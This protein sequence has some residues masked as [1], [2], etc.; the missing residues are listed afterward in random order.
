MRLREPI[1]VM[2]TK[3][4]YQVLDLEEEEPKT[5]YAQFK[6]SIP[7]YSVLAD[8]VLEFLEPCVDYDM[9]TC[10]HLKCVKCNRH[11]GE[12]RQGE[13]CTVDVC[14][15]CGVLKVSEEDFELI[16]D[17]IDDK[18]KNFISK[19]DVTLSDLY[20]KVGQDFEC[21]LDAMYQTITRS[22]IRSCVRN[23]CRNVSEF[24]DGTPVNILCHNY[25]K[26]IQPVTKK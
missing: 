15:F 25:H 2:I 6:S 23:V 20:N 17:Y 9:P 12:I 19:G 22:E 24:L 11:V 7:L 1:L 21:L 4:Y 18:A 8:H 10:T 16:R 3:N 5:T 26:R 14:K 13:G